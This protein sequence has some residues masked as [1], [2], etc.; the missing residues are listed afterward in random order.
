MPVATT[1]RAVYMCGR[2]SVH[3]FVSELVVVVAVEP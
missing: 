2:D 3:W 1:G